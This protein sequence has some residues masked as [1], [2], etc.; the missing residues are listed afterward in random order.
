MKTRE[1]NG[2]DFFESEEF[3]L[4]IFRMPYHAG[5]NPPHRHNFDELMIVSGGSATHHVPKKTTVLERG[6]VYFIPRGAVHSYDTKPNEKVE[7]INILF[8]FSRL[9]MTGLDINQIPAFRSFLLSKSLRPEVPAPLKL[10]A[11]VLAQVLHCVNQMEAEL[12]EQSA[13]YLSM[14]FSYFIRLLCL[15]VRCGGLHPVSP[16]RP[17][18]LKLRSLTMYLEEHLDREIS[19][20]EMA[21][22]VNASPSYLRVLFHKVYGQSPVNYVTKLRISRAMQ[23]LSNAD[24]SITDVAFE[25]GFSDSNYFTRVFHKHV[26]VCPTTFRKRLLTS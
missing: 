3:P 20:T 23:L 12:S 19:V 7:V 6:D 9:P 4:S 11:P 5:L 15:L 21:K 14:T 10:D 2:K 1:L 22:Y 8:E 24:H 18:A 25:T 17:E 13:G 26:G 16:S